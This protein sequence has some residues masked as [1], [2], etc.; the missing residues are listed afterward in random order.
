M[1][2][3]G[4]SGGTRAQVALRPVVSLLGMVM[5]RGNVEIN[6]PWAQLQD[7]A[8]IATEKQQQ[9]LQS[10]LDEILVLDQELRSLRD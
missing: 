10:Q 1:N 5:T 6:V 9:I 8:F 7:G 2:W 4:N 3:G